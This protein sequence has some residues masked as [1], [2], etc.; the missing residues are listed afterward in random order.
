MPIEQTIILLFTGV[1]IGFLA[2]MLGIGGGLI[3]T[4]V[5]YWLY[6]S[7][8]IDP[9]IAIKMS[10]ATSL[11]VILPTAISGVWR[12]Q[13]LGN[14]NWKIASFMG[15][16]TFAGS[17]IGA[18]ITSILPGDV[19][20]VIFGVVVLIMAARMFTAKISETNR[21]VRQNLWLWAILALGV[22]ILTGIL[23]LGGGIFIIPILVLILGF[24][25]R[26]AT[27]T[28]LAMMLFTSVGGIIGYILNGLQV[29][30]LPDHT[31]GYIYWPA[32]IALTLGSI[33]M[34]QLGAV[35][36]RKASSKLLNTLL[37]VIQTYI[38]LQMIGVIDWFIS[39]FN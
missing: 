33:F 7:A 35:V 24:T 15:I 4:P 23:G 27:A 37:V 36:C 6:T 14:I 31:I 18:T 21:P 17:I 38:G 32:W 20:K 11:A 39:L 26:S 9:D 34:V 5:Q 8:G 30:G 16:F 10:F 28:S 22:G 13:R 12:H 29:T 2:G 25:I 19:L 1:V 3:M